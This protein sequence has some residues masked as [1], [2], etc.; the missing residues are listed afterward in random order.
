MSPDETFWSMDWFCELCEAETEHDF[1]ARDGLVT[2]GCS[3]CGYVTDVD[4][5]YFEE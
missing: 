4:P 5:D 1:A 2:G 3:E